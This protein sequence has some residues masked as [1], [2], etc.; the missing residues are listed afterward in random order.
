[1]AYSPG[2]CR[3]NSLS[4][5]VRAFAAAVLLCC[6]AVARSLLCCCCAAVLL[7]CY[8][9]AAAV[10]LL[11]CCC[12]AAVLLRARCCATAVLL[13]CCCGRHVDPHIGIML[14]PLAMSKSRW[15][16]W[17][18]LAM[19]ESRWVSWSPW[20]CWESRW[21]PKAR[22]GLFLG[23]VGNPAGAEVSMG[24]LWGSLHIGSCWVSACS[25]ARGGF[26]H[27]LGPVVVFRMFWGPWWF[28]E[29]GSD[30]LRVCVLQ[31]FKHSP[32]GPDCT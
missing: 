12:A 9:C 22:R 2:V 6:C 30:F 18:P 13:L 31:C 8:C 7:L 16:S 11:C 25:G 3:S 1:M 24:S 10:L 14:G 23:H 5:R 19:S 17:S 21:G 27:V 4:S 32:P 29:V 15:V 26:P 28:S 20:P